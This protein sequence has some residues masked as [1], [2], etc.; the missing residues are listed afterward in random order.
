MVEILMVGIDG[1][2]INSAEKILCHP[3]HGITSATADTDH[4]DV[5]RE[6]LEFLFFVVGHRFVIAILAHPPRERNI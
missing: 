6:W 3:G 5:C 2:K 4:F 1:D